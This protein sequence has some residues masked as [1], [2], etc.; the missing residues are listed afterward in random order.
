MNYCNK[1][2]AR[3]LSSNKKDYLTYYKYIPKTEIKAIVQISHGMC[4]HIG[5]YDDFADYLT[6]YGILVCGNDH[7]GHGN[8]VKSKEDYGYFGR[9]HGAHILVRDQYVITKLMK[10][11]YPDIPYIL[12]GH[13]MGSFVARW[14]LEDYGKSLDAAII[15]GTSG[16]ETMAPLGIFITDMIIKFKG[17]RYR[18]DFLNKMMFGTYNSHVKNPRTISDWLSRDPEMVDNYRADE[19]CTFTF[20]ARGYHDLLML[21]SHISR[22]EW[23]GNVPDNLPIMLMSGTEDPVGHYGKGVFHVYKR[24]KTAGKNVRLKLYKGARHE[25]LNETNRLEVYKN[26]K[27]W[28][29]RNIAK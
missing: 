16:G 17:D 15:C 10:N 19:K 27:N 18:S 12:F 14:Y 11:E 1:I 28:I 21:L 26:I 5:R 29:F 25:P 23:A 2:T 8:S 3:T 4:E 20:T 22:K 24:L 9:E 7:L 13:S 6:R